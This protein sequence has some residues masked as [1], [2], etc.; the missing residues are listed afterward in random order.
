MSALKLPDV[1]ITDE[2]SMAGSRD[3]YR[4]LSAVDN[5]TKL[6]LTG[7]KK[8]LP[9]ISAGRIHDIIQKQTR[10]KKVEMKQLL[11]QKHGSNAQKVMTAFTKAEQDHKK[12][13]VTEALREM[14][15]Q[16][17]I[18]QISLTKD[19]IKTITEDA[20]Q[21]I[22]NGKSIAV[23]CNTVLSKDKIN[24]SIRSN[25][26]KTGILKQDS[27]SIK[28][29]VWRSVSLSALKKTSAD[30][31][32]KADKIIFTE[33]VGEFKQWSE[34]R[35]KDIN[36][37]KNEIRLYTG[38]NNRSVSVE[39]YGSCMQLV[40]QKS[41]DIQKGDRIVFLK[42]SQDLNVKNGTTG[43]VTSVRDSG[44]VTVRTDDKNQISFNTKDK[45][46]KNFYNHFD[47]G[48][49]L[50]VHKSQGGTYDEAL[51][52][53]SSRE[54]TTSNAAYVAIT[55][56]KTNVKIFTDNYDKLEQ[57]TQNFYK[58]MTSQDRFEKKPEPSGSSVTNSSQVR[59]FFMG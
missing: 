22:A 24:R 36:K 12:N 8:Q 59:Q 44:T 27:K 48:Y 52:F 58:K 41:L 32:D 16:G 29:S 4:I 47:H 13:P 42:N 53:N 34:Y 3:I 37:N 51:V 50:T 23:L 43:S 49:A 14:K 19:K 28:A 54:K 11:R 35:I 5:K 57:Q 46:S 10:V 30:Q 2:I 56:A 55:R 25:L 39:N 21:K 33:P 1:L 6:I 15:R 9:S 38:E 31:Y 40:A 45:T 18:H 17:N 26:I 7:D 20:S